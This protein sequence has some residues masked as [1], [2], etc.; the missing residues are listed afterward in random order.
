VLIQENGAILRLQ[1]TARIFQTRFDFQ[2]ISSQNEHLGLF[3]TDGTICEREI[4]SLT[5]KALLINAETSL[6]ENPQLCESLFGWDNSTE[7][8]FI[9]DNHHS[10]DRILDV[11]CG[12]GRILIPLAKQGYKVDGYDSSHA[13]IRYLQTKLS[14]V[15]SSLFVATF[16]TFLAPNRYQTVYASLNTIRYAPSF[17]VLKAHL[18][19]IRESLKKGGRYLVH[20]TFNRSCSTLSEA[21]WIAVHGQRSFHVSWKFLSAD[22]WH[23]E[24]YEEVCLTD[25]E[26]GKR[27]RE[28]QKQ[29][30]LSIERFCNLIKQVGGFCIEEVFDERG[31]RLGDLQSLDNGRYWVVLRKA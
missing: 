15:D 2:I 30:W 27:Y 31:Q 8:A 13:L 23:H 20:A 5:A 28:I 21:T 12:W 17:S 1:S 26:S 3:N 19:C 11:G 14:E 16:E 7:L 22:Y 10:N 6:F 18:F 9:Q 25:L 29:L 4:A 24:L